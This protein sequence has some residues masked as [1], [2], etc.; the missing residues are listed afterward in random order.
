MNVIEA[1]LGNQASG[2]VEQL[3]QQFGL[4][5]SQTSSALGALLPALAA[6][7]KRNASNQS[8]LD[9]LIGA[10]SGGQH[11]QYLDDIQSLGRPETADDGN[12]I[13]GHVFGS[14]QVSRE[15]AQRASAQSG[16]GPDILKRMLPVVATVVMGAMAKRQFGEASAQPGL[17]SQFGGQ[18][19]GGGLLDM[20]TPMLDAD[21]D[22]SM[23]NDVI[24]MIGKFM[25][26][27]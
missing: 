21:R 17:G 2:V 16:V 14:K 25:G 9:S 13:L 7:F 4:D 18:S 24:G 3:G 19:G 27:R 22:G 10:L 8:G 12:G 6:G 11:G 23:V 20:L 1:L 26:G 15:V 5:E